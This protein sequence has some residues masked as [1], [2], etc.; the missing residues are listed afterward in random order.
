MNHWSE[1]ANLVWQ[2]K[3]NRSIAIRH[4]RFVGKKEP[5]SGLLRF[6]LFDQGDFRRGQSDYDKELTMGL[7]RYARENLALVN[8]YIKDPAVTQVRNHD[9]AKLLFSVIV[10]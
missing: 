2:K 9:T 7:F 10:S 6:N 3:L 5:A 8:I 4:K 1:K